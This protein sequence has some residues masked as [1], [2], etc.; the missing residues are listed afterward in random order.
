[1]SKVSKRALLIGI[2]QYDTFGSLTGCVADV[3]ALAPLFEFNADATKT[4]N[5]GLLRCGRAAPT[6]ISGRSSWASRIRHRGGIRFASTRIK[7]S[8][9]CSNAC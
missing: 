9:S 6:T 2:D 8:K 1:M 5:F 3:K 4:R 7:A